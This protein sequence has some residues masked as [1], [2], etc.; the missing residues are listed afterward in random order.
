MME[1]RL[2]RVYSRFCVCDNELTEYIKVNN[3]FK[4]QLVY[5]KMVC[6]FVY[7]YRYFGVAS[8]IFLEVLRIHSHHFYTEHPVH[9]PSVSHHFLTKQPVYFSISVTSCHITSSKNTPCIFPSVSHSVTSLPQK[10]PC[11]FFHQ[12]RIVSHH[13]LNEHPVYF[14][15]SVTSCHITFS[16]NSLYIFPS[17]S[18]RVRSLPHQTPCTFS[19]S[20]TSATHDEIATGTKTLKG[21]AMEWLK[22]VC[23]EQQDVTIV[24][25]DSE[26][27]EDRDPANRIWKLEQALNCL[28]SEDRKRIHAHLWSCTIS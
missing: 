26:E 25:R 21:L 3:L 20:V 18:H 19:I 6:R 10:T 13:F 24:E 1:E 27:E 28:I 4:I 14:S 2:I 9:F 8:C 15:T 16:Q 17:V 12:C 5:H 11:I 22:T 23:R 7:F